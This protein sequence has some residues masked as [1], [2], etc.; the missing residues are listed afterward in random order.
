MKSCAS[1]VLMVMAVAMVPQRVLA[2]P[3][4][5]TQGD[6]PNIHRTDLPALMTT[7]KPPYADLTAP[8]DPAITFDRLDAILEQGLTGRR[9]QIPYLSIGRNGSYFYK[10]ETLKNPD[11][12]EQIGA[13]FVA[14]LSA[15]RMLELQRILERTNWL[16]AVGGEGPATHTDAG[17]MTIAVTRDG[18]T[19]TVTLNGRRPSPYLELQQFLE[20]LD[21]QEDLYSRLRWPN[22]RQAALRELQEAISLELG[23]RGTGA[24]KPAVAFDRYYEMFAPTLTRWYAGQPDE[25]R[26]AIDLMVVLKKTDQATHVGRLRFD[27][28]S[29]IRT[30]VAEA[31]P[32]LLGEEAIP[33]LEEMIQS[34]SEARWELI[35]LGDPAVPII[36]SLIE[37]DVS[38]EGAMSIPLIRAYIDHWKDIPQ[39]I[40]PRIVQAVL[41]NLQNDAVRD[42]MSYHQ[43]LLKLA[44]EEEPKPLTAFET[45]QLFLKQLSA[46]DSKG[47]ERLRSNTGSLEKWLQLRDSLDP[48]TELYVDSI[49]VDGTTGFVLTKPV[50]DKSGNSTHFIV[51]L[52]LNRK[53]DWR[54]GPAVAEPSERTLY[55]D[56]FLEAHP[57]AHEVRP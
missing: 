13:R 15:A 42:R 52:N 2:K 10:T 53:T 5:P 48:S 41:E 47:L 33:L 3:P 35:K 17:T 44:G 24:R 32:V 51:F 34:T 22:E 57:K 55:K 39:P 26:V 14:K 43:Q 29:R 46:R 6:L 45:A 27:R 20:D 31:L 30:A 4:E 54:V 1:V 11:G 25:L 12:I 21:G 37:S 9:R 36:A 50:L 18:K 19:K 56:R 16:T 49:W 38:R 8:V 7:H 28:D 23:R 40:D